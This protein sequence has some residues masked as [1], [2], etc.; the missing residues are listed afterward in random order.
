M[1]FARDVYL[2]KLLAKR[3]NGRVKVITGIRGSGKSFLL[4]NL[5]RDYLLAEGVKEDQIVSIA[6][7]DMANVVYRDPFKLHE[8]IKEK[9]PSSDTQYYIFI[10]EIQLSKAVPNPYVDVEEDTSKITFIDVLLGLIKQSNLDVYVTSSNAKMLVSDVPTQFRDRGDQ[11]RVY[12]L[13]F[14]E[15][16]PLYENQDL[17]FVDYC[18]Y[19]GMPHI[20]SLQTPTEKLQYLQNLFQETYLPDVLNQYNIQNTPEVLEWL[21]DFCVYTVGSLTNPSQLAKMFAEDKHIK[22]S[23]HTLAKYLRF[24]AEGYLLYQVNRYDL[25]KS[26]YFTTPLKYYFADVGLRNARLNF[27]QVGNQEGYQVSRQTSSQIS[28]Q[29]SNRKNIGVDYQLDN[30]LDELQ[31]I[32]NLIYNELISRGYTVDLGVLVQEYRR[33]EQRQKIQLEVDFVVN[34]GNRRFYIQSA[35]NVDIAEDREQIIAPLKKIKDSFK[36]IVVVRRRIIPKYD[37]AGI[38]Y[39]GIEDF[40]LNDKILN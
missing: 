17:A 15:V 36:K 30:Q 3:K 19:G 16:S 21:L 25:K 39:I 23:S 33:G 10:D 29:V 12:P 20:Y 34:Q 14:A 26:R 13:S 32:Q 2:Q 31:L 7:D 4:F 11:I 5:Y 28:I 6:L 40:L 8:Y 9:T 27:H 22:I 18:K 1:I 24:F 35:L 38:F 37:D